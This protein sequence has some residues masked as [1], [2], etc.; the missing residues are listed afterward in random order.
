MRRRRPLWK[1][2]VRIAICLL[3]LGWIFHAIF[4]AEGRKLWEQMGH[5][6]PALSRLDQWRLAWTQGPIELWNTLRLVQPLAFF[7]SVIFMGM[8]IVLG[9]LR[10]RM[11]LGVQGI[12]LSFGRTAEIT[13]VAHFFNSFLLGTAGGDLLKAYYA[14]RETHH[15]KTEAVMTVLVDR[16]IGLFVMLIF[17]CLM[18]L[19]NLDLLAAHRRLAAL[20][21][22]ILLLALGGAV[23]VGL[24][25]W[26]GVSRFWPQARA[27]L[28]RLPQGEMLERALEACRRY[29][30]E[31][32][33]FFRMV[34][35]SMLL[36]VMCVLQ[37]YILARGMGLVIS[38][39][40]LFVIV[41]IIVCVS[42]LP[43]TPNGLGVRENLYVLMLAVPEIN[44]EPT[45]ALS[46]SLLAFAGSMLWSIFG[47]LVYVTRKD[48]DHLDEIVPQE[49]ADTVTVESD[50]SKS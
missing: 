35:I 42:A 34:V 11:V 13:L 30:R 3:L 1:T 27:W 39:L 41:P 29:G 44:V 2:V 49:P 31:R 46:L 50:T 4:L 7:Y 25:L 45:R 12:H 10:W 28:K 40:A 6:W 37:I 21:W 26:G 43:I 8:T 5:S 48:R 32:G 15:K 33:F 24:S 22:F 19:P 23:F 38:P 36:N 16:I 47:G 20:A 17:A 18:M 14:A 9:M